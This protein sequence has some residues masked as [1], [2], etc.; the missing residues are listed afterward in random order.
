MTPDCENMI[1]EFARRLKEVFPEAIFLAPKNQNWDTSLEIASH[2]NP[3]S[4]YCGSFISLFREITASV[5]DYDSKERIFVHMLAS[6]VDNELKYGYLIS[7]ESL[8]KKYP[9]NFYCPCGYDDWLEAN[10]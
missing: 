1:S 3:A 6:G 7:K 4:Q 10:K 2:L 9:E 8:S 5:L